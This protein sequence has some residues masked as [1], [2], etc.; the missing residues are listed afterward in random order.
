MPAR[1]LFREDEAAVAGNLE[2]AACGLDQLD[3]C[4]RKLLFDLGLQPGGTREVTSHPAIF[5]RYSKGP[6]KAVVACHF[7]HLLKHESALPFR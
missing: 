4:L 6:G 2:D 7:L 1:L 3:F 5:Y